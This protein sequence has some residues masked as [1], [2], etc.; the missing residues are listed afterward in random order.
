MLMKVT[1]AFPVFPPTP[2]F[3][4]SMGE[5]RNHE[6]K[7]VTMNKYKEICLI[8]GCKYALSFIEH[9]L[10]YSIQIKSKLQLEVGA[11]ISFEF[12]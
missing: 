10:F 12:A 11:A 6:P 2:R 8:G 5:N 3:Y 1:G 9:L 4:I 7:V